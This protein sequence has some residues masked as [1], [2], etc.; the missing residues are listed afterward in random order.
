MKYSLAHLSVTKHFAI[1]I[2]VKESVELIAQIY[3]VKFLMELFLI[4][5]KLKHSEVHRS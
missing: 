3:I 5:I 1:R 2:S 4:K